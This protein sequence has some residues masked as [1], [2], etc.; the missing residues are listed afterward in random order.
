VSHGNGGSGSGSGNPD[1]GSAGLQILPPNEVD[2]GPEAGVIETL[3]DGFT[4]ADVGGFQLGQELGGPDGGTAPTGNGT[5]ANVLLGVVRDFVGP[6][7]S[8]DFQGEY[9][10][11]LPTPGLVDPLLASTQ[12]PTYT[13]L[14]EKG[15]MNVNMSLICPYHAETT[16][17]AMF[18]QWYNYTPGINRPFIVRFF[19]APQPNGLFTFDSSHFFPLDGAGFGTTPNAHDPQGNMHNFSFTTELHTQFKFAGSETFTFRGDDDIWVFINGHLAVDLGGLHKAAE[20]VVDLA[21]S[22]GTLSITPGGTYNLDL[23]H[24]ERH[25]YDSNFRID[26]NLSFVNC[27]TV[28]EDVR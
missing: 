25:D 6:S 19:F 28:P 1:P 22:A 26:T 10:G 24:A 17:K 5:C 27:G 3:P 23:F 12:K 4:A 18:D 14:C 16:S 2:A 8:T 9:Y 20:K 13:G 11:E 15:S 21:A 7:P